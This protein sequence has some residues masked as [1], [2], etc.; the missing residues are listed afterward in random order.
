MAIPGLW[1][2]TD[3]TPHRLIATPVALEAHLE[4]WI[5][6]EPA[7]LEG[8]LQVVG[9]QLQTEAGPLDLLAVDPFGRLVV[10]E[11][12]RAMV[13]RDAIAQ[14]LDYAS[15]INTLTEAD[16]DELT[17]P[18]LR[19]KLGESAL[20]L[21]QIRRQRRG[22]AESE[23]QTP[24][25]SIY[26]VGTTLDPGLER[27]VSYL[28]LTTQLPIR[29]VTIGAFRL[30]TGQTFLVRELTENDSVAESR[31]GY[32]SA[33]ISDLERLA[34]SNGV[35]EPFRVLRKAAEEAGF[36]ARAWKECVMYTPA[37]KRNRGLFTVYATAS[38]PGEVAV[39]VNAGAFPDFFPVSKEDAG[40]ALGDGWKR[41][42]ASA[43]SSFASHLSALIAPPQPREAV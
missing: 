35:G 29:V 37:T 25:I 4:A 18:Y 38:A 19:E 13:K 3:D 20:P 36:Y 41:M 17:R 21:S 42:S 10:V 26:L 31:R 43:A 12:K 27:I 16:L 5:E 28:A 33:T 11:I 8:G 22:E 40:T 24:D 32:T 15:C 9:K 7:L 2:L 23:E 1:Q 30:P 6:R 39:Y 34:D 14:A